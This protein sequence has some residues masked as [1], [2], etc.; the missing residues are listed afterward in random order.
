MTHDGTDVYTIQYPFISVGSTSGIGTFA[1][2]YSGTDLVLS[3]YPD[4]DITG[5]YEVQSLNKFFYEDS[6]TVNT[7]PDLT[8]GPVTEAVNLAFYNAKNGDR[9]NKLDFELNHEGTPIFAKTF[10]PSDST[11]L[12]TE[13]G[14]FTIDDHFFSTGERLNYTPTRS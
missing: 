10:D 2:E 7:P 1:G 14:I 8:Y 11:I 3:F 12:D 13:T 6:D 4:P 9:S 5:S